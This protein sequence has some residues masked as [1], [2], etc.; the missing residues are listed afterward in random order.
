MLR[1]ALIAAA[2]LAASTT[3]HTAAWTAEGMYCA[4]GNTTT[5]TDN[6]NNLPVNPLYN[7]SKAD[8]WFQHDRG[9]DNAPPA[10]DSFLE[11]PAGGSFTVELAHNRAQT[12]L[13]YDGAFV[14]DWP[15]G[16]DHPDDMN[17]APGECVPDGA[18]HTSNQSYAAGTA[19][20]ISYQSDLSAVTLENL[21]VFSVL[22]Q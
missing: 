11:I 8:W 2:A 7:L 12:S 3:A 4:F 13:A 1:T 17:A 18:L 9:C 20:A 6:N 10:E 5:S 21:A 19:F 15:D 14:S 16:K 22:E